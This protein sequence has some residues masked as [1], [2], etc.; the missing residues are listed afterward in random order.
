MILVLKE[1]PYLENGSLDHTEV[2][3]R[4]HEGKG[5]LI[6]RCITRRA[7]ISGRCCKL[8]Q[9]KVS[10]LDISTGV[11]EDV[12]RL[13]IL[14]KENRMP[15]VPESPATML[16]QCMYTGREGGVRTLWMMPW[17]WMCARPASSC[18]ITCL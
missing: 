6:T 17:L 1:T 16:C 2:L 18:R 9:A 14:P 13:Q 15:L 3:S 12:G 10:Q 11:I 5:A 4:L 8:G 7:L